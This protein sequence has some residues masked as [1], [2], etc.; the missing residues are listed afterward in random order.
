MWLLEQTKRGLANRANV[1]APIWKKH[2]VFK[3]QHGRIGQAI[4]AAIGHRLIGVD[5]IPK[6]FLAW[7]IMQWRSLASQY[8]MNAR[9]INVFVL[10]SIKYS[11]YDI[12]LQT[13]I[14]RFEATH[15]CLKSWTC[16]IQISLSGANFHSNRRVDTVTVRNI[17]KTWQI[18]YAYAGIV[19]VATMHCM[20]LT[21]E[22]GFRNVRGGLAIRAFGQCPV[23]LDRW[24]KNGPLGWIKK[25]VEKILSR[26]TPSRWRMPRP[27]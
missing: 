9:I 17:N 1:H 8:L 3:T 18:P 7:Y 23:G 4:L 24:V 2:S 13:V 22:N 16:S 21:T 5:R 27:V 25:T 6:I 20:T 26:K 14:H 15:C 11:H 12:S 10:H 19:W